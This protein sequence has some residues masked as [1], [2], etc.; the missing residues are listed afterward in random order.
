MNHVSDS[1]ALSKCNSCSHVF[2]DWKACVRTWER[3]PDKKEGHKS[4]MDILK[5]KYVKDE[6]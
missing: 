6:R 5:D 3:G 4:A 2:H 1:G